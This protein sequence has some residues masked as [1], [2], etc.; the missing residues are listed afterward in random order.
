MIAHRTR[1]TLSLLAFRKNWSRQ[2]ADNGYAIGFASSMS[3]VLPFDMPIQVEVKKTVSISAARFEKE[4]FQVVI[5]AFEYDL[6]NVA[7]KIGD[8]KSE[9]GTILSSDNLEVLTVGYVKTTTPI[10]PMSYTGWWPDT[11]LKEPESTYAAK[12]STM[13]LWVRLRTPADQAAGIYSGK[14]KVISDNKE[15]GKFNLKIRVYNFKVPALSPIPLAISSSPWVMKLF[16]NKPWSRMKANFA[17]TF[18]DY[19]LNQN[20]IYERFVKEKLDFDTLCR[21]KKENRLSSFN[22]YYIATGEFKRQVAKLG[23]NRAISDIIK[24]IKP[25]YEQVAKLNLLEQSIIWGFDEISTKD[26]Y[27]LMAKTFADIK[28]HYP[29]VTT[30][31]DGLGILYLAEKYKVNLSALDVYVPRIHY[32]DIREAE[33]IRRKHKKVA[34]YICNTPW[35]PYPN[36]FIDYQPLQTRIIMG[37]MSAKLRIEGFLYYSSMRTGPERSSG[38]VD[39]IFSNWPT[40]TVYGS[41]GC[42]NWFYPGKDGTVVPSFRAENFRDG[43]EDLAYWQILKKLVYQMSQKPNLNQ[44]EQEWLTKAEQ[45]VKIPEQVV[46]GKTVFTKDPAILGKYREQLGQLIEECPVTGR[47]G[48]PL[49]DPQYFSTPTPSYL[50]D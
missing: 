16:S 6:K 29:R 39:K 38:P 9:N 40:K 22:L 24:Q 30:L 45:A 44:T 13:S 32:Y 35:E 1:R 14:F 4:S 15:L 48:A 33:K 37:F 28:K 49:P 19:Y 10:Y 41:N 18:A 23:Y 31:N 5:G 7:V 21:Q 26:D 12:N 20:L 50:L 8:L 43:L 47:T 46:K 11:L 27:E 34:W 25:R 2:N 36:F 17:D 3:K 42:G